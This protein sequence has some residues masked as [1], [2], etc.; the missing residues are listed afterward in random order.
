[1]CCVLSGGILLQSELDNLRTQTY[2][3]VKKEVSDQH[4]IDERA[5]N[6]RQQKLKNE[7]KQVKA[8]AK[9][10][11]EPSMKDYVREKAGGKLPLDKQTRQEQAVVKKLKKKLNAMK[12]EINDKKEAEK[13]IKQQEKLAKRMKAK[14]EAKQKESEKS[15]KA[16][17]GIQGLN[18]S[19]NKTLLQP[20]PGVPDKSNAKLIA[21]KC[22]M[23]T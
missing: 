21:S 17:G 15:L 1:M 9:K 18:Y 12:E 23:M 11:G 8:K 14:L 3:K 4:D 10:P 19:K 22:V 20:D 6:K 2:E 7:V 5:L 16:S 13:V